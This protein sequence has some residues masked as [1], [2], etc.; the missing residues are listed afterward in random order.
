MITS[1]PLHARAD[2]WQNTAAGFGSI[3][4]KHT[5]TTYGPRRRMSRQQLTWLYG[6]SWIC[7][8][9]VDKLVDDAFRATGGPAWRFKAIDANVDEAAIHSRLATWGLEPALRRLLKWGRLYG[10]ALMLYPTIGTG[11]PAHP[12]DLRAPQ[13]LYQPQVV[14]AD[15]ALPVTMD[16]GFGSPTFQQVLE[17][18]VTGLLTDTVR[19]HCSR[20]AKHEPID[21]PLEA[22]LDAPNRW[23]PSILERPY[24]EIERDGAAAGHAVAMMYIASVLYVKLKNLRN[25][26]KAQGGKERVKAIL[27]DCRQSLDALGLL[28]LDVEDEIGNLAIQASSVHELARL[29]RDRVA[30]CVDGMP[31]EI[32]LNESPTGLRGGELSGAQAIWNGTVDAFRRET[33]EPLLDRSL[34][35]AFACWG[36]K[37]ES[38]EYEWSPLFRPDAQAEAIIYKTTMDADAVG[39]DKG[40]FSPDEAR[41]HRLIQGHPF[42]PIRVEP[43]TKAEPLALGEP[44]VEAYQAAEA[45][46]VAAEAMNGAQISSLVA[47]AGDP[48][49][50][51]EQKLGIISVAFPS[52]SQAQAEAIVGPA[53]VAGPD[54][55][56]EEDSIEQA[57]IEPGDRIKIQEAAKLYGVPTAAISAA[58]RRGEL[59]SIGLGAH[60]IVSKREL[61][62]LAS[63][64]LPKPAVGQDDPPVAA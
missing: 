47:V 48:A 11:A 18:D 37:A 6:Q 20:T 13:A 2:D 62:A 50:S 42:G 3:R 21:L 54:D 31:R 12:I 34:E 23:G 9:I 32:L 59:R 44:E 38:W 56:P 39:I 51:R 22:L 29:I 33:I 10:G 4:D 16:V 63:G 57:P 17:Y 1:V 64:Q 15:D 52:I 25:E 35:L 40:L 53:V 7:A 8:R 61:Q 14:I 28:G 58:I 46:P 41:E 43:G 26:G 30:A 19:V 27:A 5:A 36:V 60:K 24:P 55:G 45:A 49:I